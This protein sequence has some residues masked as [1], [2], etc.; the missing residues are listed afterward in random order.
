MDLVDEICVELLVLAADKLGTH[1]IHFTGTKVQML[2]QKRYAARVRNSDN[3][4]T[5]R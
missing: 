3:Q 2:T 4:K 1:F 5:A